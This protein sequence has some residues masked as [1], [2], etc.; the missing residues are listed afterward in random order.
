[1]D[2]SSMQRLRAAVVAGWKTIIIGAIAMTISY[3]LWVVVMHTKP[4]FLL[5]LWGGTTWAEMRTI[6]LWF[7]GVFKL[8]LWAGILACLFLTL[9]LRGLRKAA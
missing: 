9:W 8:M 3:G 5:D 1:M 6:T 4:W 2:E 7:F